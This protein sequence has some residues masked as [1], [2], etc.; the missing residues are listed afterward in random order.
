LVVFKPG[1]KHPVTPPILL[2]EHGNLVFRVKR[3][4][5]F[6]LRVSDDSFS[7]IVNSDIP[8][9]IRES[10]LRLH[11]FSTGHQRRLSVL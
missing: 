4:F 7:L 1:A 5:V 2:P 9:Y 8:G 6:I 11:F 10:L 3:E